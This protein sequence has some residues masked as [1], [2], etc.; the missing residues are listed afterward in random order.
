M[1][2]HVEKEMKRLR[3]NILPQMPSNLFHDIPAGVKILHLYICNFTRKMEDIKDDDI[4]KNSD[5]ISW[6]ETHLGHSDTLTTDMMGISK[7]VL[8]VHC[9]CNNRGGGVAL[10]VN[11]KL[12]PKQIRINTILENAAVKMS[13][14]IQMIVVS[15]YRP[16]STPIDLCRFLIVVFVEVDFLWNRTVD[17]L[18]TS[19]HPLLW[20]SSGLKG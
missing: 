4:F 14:P 8:I 17:S 19:F 12:N 10:I 5:I 1:L 2:E 9:D 11:K 16:P 20:T 7:N 13:E 6:N 18:K 3:K 15:V